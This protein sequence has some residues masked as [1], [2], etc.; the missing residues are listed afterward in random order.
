MQWKLNFQSNMW[1]KSRYFYINFWHIKKHCMAFVSFTFRNNLRVLHAGII[2]EISWELILIEII[3]MSIVA[4]TQSLQ[5][6][7][8]HFAVA[9]CST[10]H[11]HK[12]KLVG[13]MNSEYFSL[14][15][16][17]KWWN[18]NHLSVFFFNILNITINIYI[19]RLCKC[20]TLRKHGMA[21]SLR[22]TCTSC[23]HWLGQTWKWFL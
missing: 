21:V 11:Y 19:R 14:N 12:K 3:T 20:Y 8:S 10:F 16:H 2:R 9:I 5:K 1:I 18:Q 4:K 6:A 15:S 13:E 23:I 22:I 17:L 7:F